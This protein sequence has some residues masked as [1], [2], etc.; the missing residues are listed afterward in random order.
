MARFAVFGSWRTPSAQRENEKAQGSQREFSH[1][2]SQGEFQRACRELGGSLARE[3]HQIFVAS[4]SERTIDFHIV[5]GILDAMQGATAKQPPILLVRSRAPRSST[6]S[7]DCSSIH[8]ATVAKNPGLFDLLPTLETKNWEEVHDSIASRADRILVLGGGTSS[9]RIAVRA[10][11]A[12]RP[13]VPVGVFG[14]AGRE[15]IQMLEKVGDQRNFPKYEYR[16]VLAGREWGP[17]QLRTSLYALGVQQDP[18]ERHKIFIN[19]RRNDSNTIAGWIHAQ[20]CQVFSDDDVFLDTETITGGDRFEETITRALEQTAIF[21][22][23]IGPNWLK[24][25]NEK[26]YKRRLDEENDFVRREIEIAL[27]HR[28]KITIIP[29]CV[30]NA[31]LPERDA[32]PESIRRLV[33]HQVFSISRDNQRRDFEA[34]VSHVKTLIESRRQEWLSRG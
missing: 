4:D 33:E 9:Y 13:I 23:I 34:L 31:V 8:E 11:A 22:S 21:L 30:E 24:S 1:E 18:K 7:R 29:V 3:K 5:Q 28:E 15:I 14:G 16:C 19:Y 25:Q 27:Q 2:L 26:T 20:L 32:L 17:D 12:G 10:L 6:D